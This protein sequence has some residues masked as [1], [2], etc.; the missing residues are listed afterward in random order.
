VVA[1]EEPLTPRAARRPPPKPAAIAFDICGPIV[2]ADIPALCERVRVV[3]QSVEA[4]RV[5]CDV[6]ALLDPDATTVDALARVQLTAR[7]LGR[8]VQLARPSQGLC[9]LLAFMGLTDVLPPATLTGRGAA[10]DRIAGNR[11][12]YRERT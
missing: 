4:D 3:L 9:E 1:P 10:A 6:G 12:Q 5:I 7:R 8:Q 11:P 2:P